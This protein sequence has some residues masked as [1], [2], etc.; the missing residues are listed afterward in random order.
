MTR[1][2]API[3]ALFFTALPALSQEASGSVTGMM[4]YQA[5]DWQIIQTKGEKGTRWHDTGDTSVE[6]RLAAREGPEAIAD[7]PDIV[8][9]FETSV[10]GAEAQARDLTITMP[11][12]GEAAP[13]IATPTNS[14]I[15]LTAL[16]LEGDVVVVSGDFTAVLSP[17]HSDRIVLDDAEEA[18]MID[19]NFQAS[20][21]RAAQD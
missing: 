15:T 4:A 14:D 9:R 8:L 19:G 2:A 6:V 16:S 18:V 1:L 17:E 3:T 7:A 11:Q 5:H 21:P 20:V 13:L 12:P 10:R